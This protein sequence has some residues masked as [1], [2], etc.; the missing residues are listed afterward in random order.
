MGQL[1][2]GSY[3]NY[4]SGSTGGGGNSAPGIGTSPCTVKEDDLSFA[5]SRTGQDPP[6]TI[7]WH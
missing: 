4:G 6:L 7:T 5:R 3:S 1:E 2:G